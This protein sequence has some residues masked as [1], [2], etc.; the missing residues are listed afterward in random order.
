MVR[1]GG[2]TTNK[3]IKEINEEIFKLK[4]MLREIESFQMLEPE[5]CLKWQKRGD[6]IYYFQ[7][8]MNQEKMVWDRKYIKKNNMALVKDLAQKQYYSSIKPIIEKELEQLTGFL[9]QYQPEKM[10]LIFDELG[11]ERK[12]LIVPLHDAKKKIYDW[13]NEDYETYM[14]HPETLKHP[15]KQ[16]EMV[17]SKSEVIIANTLYDFREDILYKY[18][19][20]LDIRIGDRIVTIHPDFTVINIHTGKIKYWEHAGLLDTSQYA[21]DITK[22]LNNYVNNGWLIGR[23]VIVTTETAENPINSNVITKIV[24]GLVAER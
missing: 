4:K 11:N 2:I 16:G 12:E 1:K 14:G 13:L 20:P 15:T 24:E 19:R 10:K 21:D 18:E 3:L 6:N 5:G 17:R 23:D 8:Y 9:S 22:R 7:Q